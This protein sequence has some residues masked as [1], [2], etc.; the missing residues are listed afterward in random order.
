MPE[1][2]I[3]P[4]VQ[5]AIASRNQHLRNQAQL[6]VLNGGDTSGVARPVQF[7]SDMDERSIWATQFA[8]MRLTGL[9][10][11]SVKAGINYWALEGTSGGLKR[12]ATFLHS[13]NG[14]L[15]TVQ[16]CPDITFE[17]LTEGDYE[18]ADALIAATNG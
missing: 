10:P 17:M 15:V 13:P 2:K 18:K 11:K 1:T 9:S 14:N 8:Y 7:P 16:N 6:A 3:D 4:A 5:A 12:T